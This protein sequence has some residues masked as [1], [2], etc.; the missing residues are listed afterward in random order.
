MGN[1]F[2]FFFNK[3]CFLAVDRSVLR[4]PGIQP[5]I[6]SK[7]AAQEAFWFFFAKK[8]LLYLS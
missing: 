4:Q 7:R 5:G 3:K 1:G 6:F 2:C 8:E